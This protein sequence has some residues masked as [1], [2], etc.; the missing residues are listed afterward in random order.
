[1]INIIY[2]K[3]HV[4]R[5]S[6][7]FILLNKLLLLIF[8][9]FSAACKETDKKISVLNF[10]PQLKKMEQTWYYKKQ[11]FTGYIVE[12]E[13]DGR[14]LYQVPIVKGK[15]EGLAKGWYNTGERLLERS[16][17]DG[18]KEGEFTQWW[19]NGNIRYLFHYKNDVFDGSQWVYF[20]DG[21]KREL[22]NYVLGEKEGVQQVWDEKSKLISNYTI[23]NKKLYGVI[24]VKSCIPTGH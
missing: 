13:K 23:K 22:S 1:M 15:E 2:K 11:I 19:P 21:K 20:P 17:I 14:L 3:Y 5:K 10:D 4:I 8:L 18:K 12:K 16:Y 7:F 9:L 24:S 6:E